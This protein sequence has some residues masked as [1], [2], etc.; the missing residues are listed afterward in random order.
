MAVPYPAYRQSDLQTDGKLYAQFE[1]VVA[2]QRSA[3]H[4]KQAQRH[5]TLVGILK[6]ALPA[7]AIGLVV[8]FIVVGVVNTKSVGNIIIKSAGISN[9]MLIME[10]PKMSGFNSDNLPYNLFAS[11]AKQDLKHPNIIKMEK[12][13]AKVPMQADIFADIKATTG[14]YDSDKEWLSLNRDIE[15]NSQDGT[16]I[17]LDTAEIDLSKGHLVSNDPV[18]VFTSNSNIFADQVEVIDNGSVIVFKQR[19]RMTIQPSPEIK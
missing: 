4:F 13:R 15:V 7:I 17:L 11:R 8:W 6:K 2:N 18:S 5:S 16:T 14:T 19:V 12:L 9:G 3:A 10:A 1:H